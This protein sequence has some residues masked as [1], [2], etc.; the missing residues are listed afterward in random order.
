M[1]INGYELPD[2]VLPRPFL[3]RPVVPPNR[4]IVEGEDLCAICGSGARSHR[5]DARG[6][7]CAS[8]WTRSDWTIASALALWLLGALCG[9]L[10][11]VTVE[12]R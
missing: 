9:L 10:Y 7:A 8:A 6:H 4:V 11:L 2:T 1:K 3:S 5:D 12:M